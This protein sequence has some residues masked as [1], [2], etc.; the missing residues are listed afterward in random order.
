MKIV[1]W[2]CIPCVGMID[3]FKEYVEN[4]DSSAI[5]ITGVL[6]DF[7][8]SMGWDDNGKLFENHLLLEDDEWT[9]KGIELLNQYSDRLHVF[10]GLC[11]NENFASLTKYA[12]KKGIKYCNMS[13]AYS[14]L[15]KGFKRIV[16]PL[17][18]K[19][20]LPLK[21]RDIAKH[22][23]GVICLSGRKPTTLQQFQTFGFKSEDIYP[24]GYYTQ[25]NNL[26][27]YKPIDDKVH[28]I[29]PGRLS[30]YKGV[31]L[32]IEAMS[33]V[34]KR[35]YHNVVCHITGQGA[36]LANLRELAL[37]L[38]VDDLVRFEG[39]LNSDD[40]NTLLSHIDVLVAPGRV[41]PWGIRINEAIQRG[42][43]V[44]VS[45]LIGAAELIEE[46]EGGYVFHSGDSK[47]LA[48]KIELLVSNPDNLSRSKKN[49]EQYKEKISCRY[50]A[51]E[52]AGYLQKIA[53]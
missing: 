21:L 51:T 39:V 6:N 25:E 42:N 40:Y 22:S 30:K 15:N 31:D 13:E 11:Y 50:K 1:F 27:D 34:K 35:G 10:N 12:I 52:L 28:I 23:S 26:V 44:I 47:D 53:K 16:K 29:C 38:D 37:R 2:W 49:N 14:N 33:L 46:S 43:A 3:V 45:D 4:I 19:C 32:L 7:R 17:Y 41:E 5:V 8:K 48:S 36:E 24:F 20:Y 9:T 18:I